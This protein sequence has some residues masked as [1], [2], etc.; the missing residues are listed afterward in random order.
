MSTQASA[1]CLLFAL[2]GFLSG[3]APLPARAAGPAGAPSIADFVRHPVY[4]VVRISPGGDYLAATVARGDQDVLAVLRTSDMSLVKVNELPDRQSVGSF[5]W[6]SDERLLFNAVRKVGSYAQPFA[7]GEWFAVDADGSHPRAVVFYGTRKVTERSK[8]ARGRFNLLD[9]LEGDDRNV[10]MEVTTPRS[11]TGVNSEVVRLDTRTGR[12]TTVARAPRENCSFALDAERSP[13]FAVCFDSEN[14]EGEYDTETELYRLGE[15]GKWA[16]INSSKSGDTRLT[17]AGTAADGR[18]YALQS[19]GGG[20]SAF[21]TLDLATGRFQQVFHDPVSDPV[22]IRASDDR[23]VIG[24]MTQAGAPQL[25]LL[26]ED[27]PDVALYRSLSEAFAGQFVDFGSATGDGRHVVVT[28]A[29][30]R[31]PGDLYLYDRQTGQARFLLRSRDWLDTEKMARVQPFS[32]TSRD[33]LTLHGY[34]TIPRGTS[35]KNLPMIVNPHGGPMGPRDSWFFN[36][37]A[38]LLASR[39]YLVMQVNF[40]GSG[41]FGKKFQDMAYG[42]WDKGIMDDVIDAT[43]WTIEQ[44]YADPE[45][46]CIY[47]GSFGGFAAMMAPVKAPGLYKCAFGYVGFYDAQVQLSKSDTSESEAG[48]RY[49]AR[50]LG[51][52]RDE[53][54]AISPVTHASKITLP[55][56]LAAGERDPRCPPEQTRN[57]Y[58]ALAKSGNTPEGLI[59]RKGEMHGF[60]EEESNIELY[61]QMLAFFDRHIGR[62]PA[63]SSVADAAAGN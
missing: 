17:V 57:M 42:Q 18:V 16:L 48:R 9:T 19:S 63:G 10:L 28:V 5:H 49:L 61:T 6:I 39:G 22:L 38:Q 33:G 29:S 54:D 23:T 46:V 58:N 2:A 35:G 59:I 37:E 52:T 31:N 41:G 20:T 1:A 51:R 43:R 3:A 36:G 40:R 56:F 45:R 14:A 27:H 50:A 47:G 32:F 62:R 44:G 12:W 13:R 30:D 60:Y 34:L 55:V 7:T 24:V 53:Q 15:D 21:G 8:S 25:T 26:D 11:S 4:G